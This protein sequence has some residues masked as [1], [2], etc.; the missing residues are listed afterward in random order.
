MTRFKV[1]LVSIVDIPDS[2]PE[3]EVAAFVFAGAA[4]L[5]GEGDNQSLEVER[6]QDGQPE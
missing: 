2:D 5:R 4:V 3:D 6:L 1:T